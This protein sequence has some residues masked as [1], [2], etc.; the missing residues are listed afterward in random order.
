[1]VNGEHEPWERRDSEPAK[2][3]A[4]FRV[5]RDLPALARKL[6]SVPELA[7]CSET[8]VRNL[9]RRWD[10]QER[11]DAWDDECHRTE[12]RERLEAIRQMHQLHRAAGRSTLTKALQAL[13]L[14]RPEQMSPGVIA[15]MI[16][17]GARLERNTLLVSIEEMQGVEEYDDDTEDAWERIAR[18]LD[19]GYDPDR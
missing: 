9:A 18:E 16:E 5:Y 8:H 7:G 13:Q 3:Y 6:T 1:M 17:L 2:D 19:P 15:R 11:V 14:L 4:V 10:W 12:D